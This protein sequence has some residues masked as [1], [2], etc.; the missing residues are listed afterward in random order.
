MLMSNNFN[1]VDYWESRYKSGGNSGSGSYGLL[2]QYKANIINNFIIENNIKSVI[3][4]GVGDGNQLSLLNLDGV[5]Y[6]GLDVSKTIIEKC[7]SKFPE[8]M[9]FYLADQYNGKS[10]LAI[11]CDVLYHLIDYTR[12]IDY[13]DRLFNMTTN[14]VIIYARDE[15][16]D[17][18]IHN[19]FREFLTYI[20]DKYKEW[21]LVDMLQNPYPA[22]EIR[23]NS[24][25][26]SASNF[27]FFSK[28]Y[29]N[30]AKS[31]IINKWECFFI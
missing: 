11:S 10:E 31:S 24:S 22:T 1:E 9:Q 20:L 30:F 5:K 4:Y 28:N 21:R 6:V 7:K 17:C 23:S 27:Y 3:D 26:T 13:I 12:F 19:K 15:N 18:S 29:L 14:Y 8:N 16:I 2:A 25:T